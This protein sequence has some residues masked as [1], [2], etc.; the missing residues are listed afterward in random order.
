MRIISGIHKGRKLIAP[1]NL[2]ARPTTDFTKESLFNIITHRYYF[3]EISVLDLFAGTGSISY[4]FASRGVS[5]ITAIDVHQGSV[6]FIDK[7]AKQLEMPIHAFKL[8][9]FSFIE[10]TPAKFDIIFA[11]PPYN[12]EVDEFK[13]LIDLVFQH[14][15]LKPEG[16][17]II[18]HSKYTDLSNF[19]NYS[20]SRKYGDSMLSFFEVNN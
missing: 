15:I 10:S 14:K 1:R 4:E 9:V 2:P 7:T 3:E 12:L 18:E 6:N 13:K 19:I 8:N 11:D 16:V 17:L 20:N 5:N